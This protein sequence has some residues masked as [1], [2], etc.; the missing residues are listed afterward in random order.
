METLAQYRKF[1]EECDRLA[2]EAKTPQYRKIL[3]EMAD[4]WRKLVE[5]S[6]T[7]ESDTKD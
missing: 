6:D 1:A 5:E 7:K 2:A 3:E 4:A